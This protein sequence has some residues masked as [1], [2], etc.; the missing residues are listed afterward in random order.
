[1]CPLLSYLLPALSAAWGQGA[2]ECLPVPLWALC[3]GET[4]LSRERQRKVVQN[5]YVLS[6]ARR[7][8]L[9]L[10]RKVKRGWAVF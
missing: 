5:C 9:R 8:K 1:M 2:R 4:L 7:L 3:I 10:V 6:K